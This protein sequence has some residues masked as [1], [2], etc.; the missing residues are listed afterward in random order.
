MK[1]YHYEVKILR[2]PGIYEWNK[3]KFVNEEV[4]IAAQ[5]DT[6]IVINDWYF[7]KIKKQ[8]CSYD[9]YLNKP[10]IRI[11]TNDPHLDNGIFYSLYSE[12]PVKPSKIKSEIQAKISKDYSWLF[13][14]I[15]L[16]IIK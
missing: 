12:N 6:Y 14:G 13:G 10:T 5:N 1:L 4:E 3:N 2:T 8:K 7:T 9:A 16:S 15:D 11:R